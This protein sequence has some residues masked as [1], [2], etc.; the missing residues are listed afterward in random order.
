MAFEDLKPYVDTVV[1]QLYMDV[2]NGVSEVMPGDPWTV[3]EKVN[4]ARGFRNQWLSNTDWTVGNDSPLS[5]EHKA[6][7]ITYRQELRD[8]MDVADI[9]D[10]VVPTP[11]DILVINPS[12]YVPPE[13][14]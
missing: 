8:M 1:T 7:W 13:E 12:P 6:A 10:I 11:P 14:V 4:F 5:D 9:D 3:E 2:V